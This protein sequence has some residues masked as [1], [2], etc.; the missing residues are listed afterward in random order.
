MFTFYLSFIFTISFLFSISLSDYF[1]NMYKIMA[2]YDK[3][4]N[5]K[6]DY[7]QLCAINLEHIIQSSKISSTENIDTYHKNQ[8]IFQKAGGAWAVYS[9]SNDS[10]YDMLTCYKITDYDLETDK[11][12]YYNEIK[13]TDKSLNMLFKDYEKDL[14]NM[15]KKS[16]SCVKINENV[17]FYDSPHNYA[18]LGVVMF[19][20]ENNYPIRI[21]FLHRILAH[22]YYE[23]FKIINVKEASG[24]R[25]WNDRRLS[26][27]SEIRLINY[28][29]NTAKKGV[30]QITL[31]KK[32]MYKMTD[33]MAKTNPEKVMDKY[34]IH[35]KKRKPKYPF[36]KYSIEP[37]VDPKLLHIGTVMMGHNG[38]RSEEAYVVILNKSNKKIWELF[39][40]FDSMFT[41][42]VEDKYMLD[43]YGK[44]Y[45]RVLRR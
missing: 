18:Y 40:P 2:L 22:A 21:K 14:K 43:L 24:W 37:G 10:T 41:F 5:S 13:D 11:T 17:D 6:G 9:S 28:A 42:Y 4:I 8:N 44:Q 15:Y 19:M 34:Y 27:I 25:S 33:N 45:Y 7:F 36:L 38:K 1:I 39:D 31:D 35:H 20:L 3:Y 26:L 12:I 32:K 30:G 29:I 16:G 23:Y